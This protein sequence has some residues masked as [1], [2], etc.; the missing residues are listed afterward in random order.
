MASEF[1]VYA[2][3]CRLPDPTQDSLPG[4]GQALLDGLSTRRVPMKGFKLTSCSLSSF[5][6]LAWRKPGG[7]G[8]LP[9]QGSHRPVR[10]RIRA[11]GS[12]NH[13]FAA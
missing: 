6:K 8:R 13:G 5:P 11:Y 10:A 3:Q 9:A 4:A 12:S 2:S 7:P 1:A